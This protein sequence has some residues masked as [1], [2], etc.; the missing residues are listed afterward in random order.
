V[1]VAA[2]CAR[3]VRDR[4]GAGAPASTRIKNSTKRHACQGQHRGRRVLRLICLGAATISTAMKTR[5]FH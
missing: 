3:L 4:P 5:G 1:A 2:I